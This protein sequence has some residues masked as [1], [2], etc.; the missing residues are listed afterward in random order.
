[1][2]KRVLDNRFELGLYLG[3][4]SIGTVYEALD[5][6]RDLIVAIKIDNGT[7]PARFYRETEILSRLEHPNIVRLEYVGRPSYGQRWRPSGEAPFYVME[8]M[9]T[10]LERDRLD[11]DAPY[12]VKEALHLIRQLMRGLVYASLEQV[13]HRD[14]KPANIFLATDR[15]IVLGDFSCALAP[16]LPRLTP[17]DPTPFGTP[18][19][20]AP[21]LLDRSAHAGPQTDVYSVGAVLYEL[22]GGVLRELT[23]AG[24]SAQEELKRNPPLALCELNAEVPQWLSE[25][26]ARAMA[27]DPTERYS[28]PADLLCAL[29]PAT[30][31][32]TEPSYTLQPAILADLS[33]Q[34]GEPSPPERKR[35]NAPHASLPPILVAPARRRWPGLGVPARPPALT[36]AGGALTLLRPSPRNLAVLAAGLLLSLLF[37]AT[38]SDRLLP[39][40]AETANPFTNISQG[41][42]SLFG[43]TQQPSGKPASRLAGG[44]ASS[45]HRKSASIAGKNTPSDER[46][47]TNSIFAS[48]ASTPG[49]QPRAPH[50]SCDYGPQSGEPRPYKAETPGH[51]AQSEGSEAPSSSESSS[52]T[53]SSTST[54]SNAS[55]QSNTNTSIVVSGNVTISEVDGKRTINAPP[56]AEITECAT[57]VT[58]KTPTST[59]STGSC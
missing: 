10:T 6:E 27:V 19:Y 38:V 28:S 52:T 34:D 2:P 53:L 20:V 59:T 26:V 11:R 17:S 31:T 55:P 37:A 25:L 22:L 58:V 1:M 57:G 21:E 23:L 49:S 47:P 5:H 35:V 48:T 39:G 36:L 30:F 32:P 40:A 29:D 50:C 44:S 51:E 24:Q 9:W 7:S 13:T 12:S 33:H 41:L 16:A 4:G 14:I 43:K 15:R 3:G 45:Q 54:Q 8:K 46:L 42:G 18:P 56:G